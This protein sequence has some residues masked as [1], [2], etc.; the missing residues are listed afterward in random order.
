MTAGPGGLSLRRMSIHLQTSPSAALT[1]APGEGTQNGVRLFAKGTPDV[2]SNSAPAVSVRGLRHS[3]RTH[4]AV[5][6]IDFEIS[7]GEIFALLGPNGA[8]KTTT[9]EILEGFRK[10]SGGDVRVLGI[11]PEQ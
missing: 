6:G 1:S 9:I 2:S 11:D 8:G 10:R 5:K 4:E 7:A 3:Y